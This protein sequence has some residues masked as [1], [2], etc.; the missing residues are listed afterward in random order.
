MRKRAISCCL[1]GKYDSPIILAAQEVI[2]KI[3]LV[4]FLIL[5]SL[6]TDLQESQSH[7]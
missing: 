2:N 5:I 3:V 1:K 6:R 4:G 7:T